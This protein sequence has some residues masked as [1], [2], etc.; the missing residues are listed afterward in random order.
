MSTEA[1]DTVGE[2]ILQYVLG[3]RENGDGTVSLQLSPE[4]FSIL[5]RMA[6]EVG[7]DEGPYLNQ[8]LAHHLG[9][10]AHPKDN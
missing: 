5:R 2:S 6:R 7:M 9:R 1:T 3:K 4:G 8:L 10:G